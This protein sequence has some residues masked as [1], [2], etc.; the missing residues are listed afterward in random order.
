MLNKLQ[1][2][3]HWDKI[4]HVLGAVIMALPAFLTGYPEVGAAAAIAFYYGR[5]QA[6]A[7][8]NLEVQRVNPY[9][10]KIRGFWNE[11]QTYF[12]MNW[13]K[14]AKW[15]VLVVVIAMAAMLIGYDIVT[16]G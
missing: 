11:V 4:G 15:D 3:K 12:F 1:N 16:G 8:R 2:L 10:L 9:G 14:D 13:S 6:Q 5:E 7:E